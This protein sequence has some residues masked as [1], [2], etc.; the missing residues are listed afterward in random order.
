LPARKHWQRRARNS[1]LLG[2]RRNPSRRR[3]GRVVLENFP[4]ELLQ[5]FARLEAEFLGE[6]EPRVFV[7]AQSVSLSSGAIQ[8]EHELPAKALAE[9]ML[10]DERL[11]LGDDVIVATESEIDVDSRLHGTKPKLAEPFDL[12]LSEGVIGEVG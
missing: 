12:A 2:S 8:R 4:V 3:Q 9:S 11:Q 5:A 6:R 7:D 1:S 10:R